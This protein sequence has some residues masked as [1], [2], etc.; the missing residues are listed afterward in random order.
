[1]DAQKITPDQIKALAASYGLEYAALMAVITVESGGVGFNPPTGKIIIR[2]EPHWFKQL[3]VDWRAQLG[4]WIN[5][6]AGDQTDEWVQFDNAFSIAPNSAMRATSWGMM[7]VMG[8]NH[9][10]VGFA[11]VGEMVDFAK[12]NEANQVALGLRFIKSQPVLLTAL[13]TKNWA[14]FALHYN[15]EDYAENQYDTRL[16]NAYNKF[17]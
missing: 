9:E 14:L 16:L 15:G 5:N 13:Q 6:T 12:V 11:T 7:Q 2:F 8:F 3:Y 17:I 4:D 1:M 10:A